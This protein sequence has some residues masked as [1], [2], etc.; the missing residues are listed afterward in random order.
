MRSFPPESSANFDTVQNHFHEQTGRGLMLSSRDFELLARWFTAGASPATICQGIDEAIDALQKPP[1]DLYGC[2]KYIEPYVELQNRHRAG[3]N[4]FA[5]TAATTPETRSTQDCDEADPLDE[6][7]DRLR[8]VSARTEQQA[9]QAVFATTM[10]RLE[11]L[12]GDETFDPFLD[13]DAIEADLLDAVYEAL[14]VDARTELERE[15]AARWGSHLERMSASARKQ[16]LRV[17]RRALLAERH[18]VSLS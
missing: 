16:T 12:R 15:I 10:D 6:A 2:R 7:I 17:R 3:R 4:D 5:G 18:G 9:L 11:S 14:G 1:R 8:A 13:L